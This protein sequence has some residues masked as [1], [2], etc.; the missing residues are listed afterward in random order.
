[1]STD[2][3]SPSDEELIKRLQ[4]DDFA[5]Y[6]QLVARFKPRLFGFIMQMVKDHALS[7]DLLQETFIRLW[8]HRMSYREIARFSTWIYTIAANLVRSEMRK[9]ARV[10]FVDLEPR[11]AGDRAQELP[12]KGPQVDD[13]V[14]G[15]MTMEAIRAAMDALPDEFREVIYLREVEE[16]SYD[17]IVEMLNIPAGTVKSR[18]NRARARLRELL[19][20][21]YR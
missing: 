17:E 14:A 16:L 19:E 5:A 9:K 15:R 1:M 8:R 20:K 18:I 2:L 7:E 10:R 13:I 3:K 6:D 12:D 4:A 21:D 11:E